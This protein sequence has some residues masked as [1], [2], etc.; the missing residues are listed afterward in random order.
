MLTG[1]SHVMRQYA[2]FDGY[3]QATHAR[4]E[5]DSSLFGKT[6]VTI[7][8]SGYEIKIRTAQ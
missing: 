6:I 8:Y 4:A 5:S 2:L 7:D 3:A 1:P